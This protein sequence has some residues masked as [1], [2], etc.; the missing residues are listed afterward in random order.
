MVVRRVAAFVRKNGTKSLFHYSQHLLPEEMYILGT[1]QSETSCNLPYFCSKGRRVK[2][3][4][5]RKFAQ[6][7]PIKS[8]FNQFLSRSAPLSHECLLYITRGYIK[9]SLI[10]EVS[11]LS[12]WR[13]RDLL[14]LFVEKRFF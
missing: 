8:I 2:I 1:S 10:F 6:K 3:I 5:K 14:I 13:K 11:N 9:S 12:P 7:L 4:V